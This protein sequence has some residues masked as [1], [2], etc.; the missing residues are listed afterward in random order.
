MRKDKSFILLISLMIILYVVSF[1][2]YESNKFEEIIIKCNHSAV[3]EIVKE[4]DDGFIFGR[5]K[6]YKEGD[7]ISGNLYVPCIE[8]YNDEGVLIWEK[9]FSYPIEAKSF[10]KLEVL[11]DN[12]IVLLMISNF[13]SHSKKSE[14]YKSYLLKCDKNG[15]EI[16]KKYFDNSLLGPSK[17]VIGDKGELYLI[18]KMSNDRSITITKIRKDGDVVKEKSFDWGDIFFR[19]AMYNKAFGIVLITPC[20]AQIRNTTKPNEEFFEKDGIIKCIDEN[21]NLKWNSYDCYDGKMTIFDECIYATKNNTLPDL[22]STSPSTLKILDKNGNDIRK[23]NPRPYY[24]NDIITLQDYDFVLSNNHS[25]IIL[26]RNGDEIL[27]HYY[28]EMCPKKII[29]TN[30]GGFFLMTCTGYMK[31]IPIKPMVSSIRLYYTECVV[32]KYDNQYR[33]E[34]H[35]T[36]NRYENV[37]LEDLI[38]PLSNGKIVIIKKIK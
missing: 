9:E 19:R 4:T 33:L 7:V 21:L 36:Y 31:M 35:K 18:K 26:N 3:S 20:S 37:A 12:S 22:S 29:K 1:F 13:N 30:D 6:L 14:I 27:E 25:I 10:N 5:M 15:K 32:M 11:K 8:K 28:K 16:W 2:Y 24:L 17:L 38:F 34:D 23:T